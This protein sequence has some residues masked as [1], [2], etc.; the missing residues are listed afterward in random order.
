[1]S[2]PLGFLEKEPVLFGSADDGGERY[3]L[4]IG[5]PQ[6]I[7]DVGV[8]VRGERD[9]LVLDN[10]FFNGEFKEQIL[11]KG[12]G[13]SGRGASMVLEGE[14]VRIF[15]VLSHES[16]KPSFLNPKDLL[17]VLPVDLIP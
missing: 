14:I 13:D 6:T 16:K 15:S 2:A 10:V 3:F 1:M 11:L 12:L 9:V 4:V 17:E 7:F 8:I 5:L